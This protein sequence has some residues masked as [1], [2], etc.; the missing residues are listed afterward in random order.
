M[1]SACSVP[2]PNTGSLCGAQAQAGGETVAGGEGTGFLWSGSAMVCWVKALQSQGGK[3][4][5]WVW[6]VP[7]EVSLGPLGQPGDTT[8]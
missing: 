5:G 8:Q 2:V 6:V 3:M 1:L 4:A 7:G